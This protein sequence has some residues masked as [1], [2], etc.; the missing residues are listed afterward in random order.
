VTSQALILILALAF[1]IVVLVLARGVQRAGGSVKAW[2]KAPGLGFGV[3]YERKH[4]V[5]THLRAAAEK[6]GGLDEVDEARRSLDE[7]SEVRH[8]NILWV[9]DH[10]DNNINEVLMLRDLGVSITQTL[11]SEKARQYLDRAQFDLLITDIG[12]E[13][14]PRAGIRFLKELR[15]GDDP[16]TIVYFLGSE[17]TAEEAEA[18]GAR[19]A[20]Q[21]PA[22]L[23]EAVLHEIQA[24]EAQP[25]APL[26]VLH[27][28]MRDRKAPAT[29][30]VAAAAKLAEAEARRDAAS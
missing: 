24:T 19:A 5:A 1:L 22:K 7:I 4:L 12:R 6:K 8:V 27:S 14:D 18:A 25:A 28:I 15:Q 3:D 16:P 11:S 21:T 17:E 13:R 2:F 9:D 23:L 26:D 29:A 30:R 10:P 20:V